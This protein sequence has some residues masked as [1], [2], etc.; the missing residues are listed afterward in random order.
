M[1]KIVLISN[2]SLADHWKG[3]R[4][5]L[6]S[7]EYSRESQRFGGCGSCRHSLASA[8][9]VL[10][11]VAVVVVVVVVVL[12]TIVA[13]MLAGR[14]V[15]RHCESMYLWDDWNTF[16]SLMK[17]THRAVLLKTWRWWFGHVRTF[18][19]KQSISSLRASSESAKWIVL[20]WHVWSVSDLSGI[21]L[22][23]ILPLAWFC[24]L[25]LMPCCPH[26]EKDTVL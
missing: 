14:Q 13:V 6:S 3:L 18:L 23:L 2:L 21:F 10:V 1:I 26:H 12:M 20:T 8:W 19:K 22:G 5:T 9:T 15:K 4:N 17:L 11:I 7:P 25:C 16:G 24:P